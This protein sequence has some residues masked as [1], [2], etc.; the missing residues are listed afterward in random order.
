MNVQGVSVK[1]LS[2]DGRYLEYVGAHGLPP[3]LTE[4]KIVEVERSPLNRRIIGGEP[5]VTGSATQQELFQLGE[6]LSAA[7]IQSVLFVPLQ[8]D[9]RV[10]GI[11]GAY[12]A[13]ADRFN[14]A[15][16]DFLRLSAKFVAIA[17][18]NARVYDALERMS[19]DR[20]RFT[21]RLA[22]NLRSPLSA[23]LSILEVVRDGYIGHLNDYQRDYLQRVDKR[24]HAMIDLINE[25]MNLAEKRRQSHSP[26]CVELDFEELAAR[27]KRTF[28]DRAAQKQI[29]L[30]LQVEE[31]LPTILGDKE[32]I[33]G[34]LENLIANSI[35]YTP[36][37]G[38][39]E[40]AII[41]AD[42][43]VLIRVSD[44]GI[45]IPEDAMP[46]LFS[47]FFRAPNA[48]SFEETGTGLGLTYVKEV[49]EQHGGHVS[50]ESK[51]NYGTR[52]EVRL[53]AAAAIMRESVAPGTNGR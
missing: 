30:R 2:A 47:E 21:L 1:L 4:H 19:T 42:G 27:L 43:A 44:T 33:E 15:D 39:I 41:P 28:Q 22:H 9:V 40:V 46:N 20:E 10:I 38:T 31:D 7:H 16:V 12:G 45:G 34:A 49:V 5:Y 36:S 13:E 3:H 17:I 37:G 53:P 50:V 18:E 48:K 24:A 11:L 51:E 52:F 26:V 8:I 25:L 32:M 29:G 35:K 14:A 6:E 23:M